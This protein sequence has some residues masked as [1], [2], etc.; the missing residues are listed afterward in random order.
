MSAEHSNGR[1]IPTSPVSLV[2][3]VLARSPDPDRLKSSYSVICGARSCRRKMFARVVLLLAFVGITLAKLDTESS[4]PAPHAK[5]T[6]MAGAVVVDGFSPA[7][8]LTMPCNNKFCE[9][10]KYTAVSCYS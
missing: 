10:L 3:V 5:I 9:M 2:D 1:S 6:P 4:A 8:N 7:N